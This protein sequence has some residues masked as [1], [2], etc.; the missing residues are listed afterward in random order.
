MS[1]AWSFLHIVDACQLQV[2]GQLAPLRRSPSPSHLY[3]NLCT[4]LTGSSLPPWWQDLM[5]TRRE[6]KSSVFT[7][8]A[9]VVCLPLTNP[10][11]Q[12]S[13]VIRMLRNVVDPGVLLQQALGQQPGQ[14]TPGGRP[15]GTLLLIKRPLICETI[16]PLHNLQPANCLLVPGQAP[17]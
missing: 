13:A 8:A 10:L 2:A 9:K 11:L 12:L 5:S 17:V 3:G 15:S 1:A 7:C 16:P 4:S 14:V 6:E